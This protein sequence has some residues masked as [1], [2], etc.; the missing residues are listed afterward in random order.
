MGRNIVR[1]RT[2]VVFCKKYAAL[3]FLA[4]RRVQ[5]QRYQQQYH[6]SGEYSPVSGSC[7]YRPENPAG[8]TPALPV[9][10]ISMHHRGRYGRVRGYF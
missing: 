3:G 10:T 7:Q 6:E 1:N 9:K 8:E 5:G 4:R 2:I